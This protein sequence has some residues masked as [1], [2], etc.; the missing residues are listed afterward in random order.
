MK[1]IIHFALITFIAACQPPKDKPTLEEEAVP[2]EGTWQLL[3]AE[4]I[5]GVDTTFKDYT[6]S[7]KGIKMLNENHFA[8]FQHDLTKGVDSTA[9]FV[10]GGGPYTFESGR[11]V[12]QLEYC[13]ARQWEGHTFEFEMTLKGDTLVQEGREKLENLGVDRIIKETYLRLD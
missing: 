7:M 5:V 6:I 1:H 4:T 10:S 9:R 3:S 11:Y 2:I 12:E 8:F 13:T